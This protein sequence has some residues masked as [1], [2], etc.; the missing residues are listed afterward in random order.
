MKA[1]NGTSIT[2]AR[3]TVNL[4]AKSGTRLEAADRLSVRDVRDSVEYRLV[5]RFA[6]E[7]DRAV[8]EGNL[9]PAGMRASNGSPLAKFAW[10][11]NAL[12]RWR[13][14]AAALVVIDATTPR[15]IDAVADPFG[16]AP[17]L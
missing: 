2:H 8:G 14:P 13:V 4:P 1:K 17:G 10:P 11:R 12:V 5:G 3:P 9:R 16:I 6:E 7:M 15:Q